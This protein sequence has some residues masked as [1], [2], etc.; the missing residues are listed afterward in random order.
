MFRSSSLGGERPAQVD[1]LHGEV[2]TGAHDAILGRPTHLRNSIYSKS[3]IFVMAAI[4]D[5]A[6]LGMS[7]E[8]GR[9]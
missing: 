3:D 5:F 2:K 8:I 9:F 1:W 4:R 7:A 6:T